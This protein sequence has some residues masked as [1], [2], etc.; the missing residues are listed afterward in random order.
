MDTCTRL[1]LG[2]VSLIQAWLPPGI[3]KK[4]TADDVAGWFC[5]AAR[6]EQMTAVNG[7][8]PEIEEGLWEQHRAGLSGD[9]SGGRFWPYSHHSFGD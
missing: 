4:P 9:M 3:W 2:A 5:Q 7:S 6:G 1:V 8:S